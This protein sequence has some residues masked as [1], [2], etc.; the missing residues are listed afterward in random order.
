MS[1]MQTAGDGGLEAAE[2]EDGEVAAD[3][4]VWREEVRKRFWRG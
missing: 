3:Q 2:C 1:T 4:Y